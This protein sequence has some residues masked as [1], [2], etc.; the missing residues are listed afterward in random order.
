MALLDDWLNGDNWATIKTKFNAA[1]AV[2]NGFAL[3]TTGQFLRKSSSTDFAVEWVDNPLPAGGDAGDILTKASGTDYDVSW[4]TPFTDTWHSIG[5]VGEPTYENSWTTL[6]DVVQ[7]TKTADGTV[8]INGKVSGGSFA[9]IDTP[10]TLFTLPADYRP[11]TKKYASAVKCLIP[12]AA[13]RPMGYIQILT[14][15]EV[16]ISS[17]VTGSPSEF[18]VNA[19]FKI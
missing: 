14:T 11:D 18:Q 13:T 7:F 3:G 6:T 5:D 1:I 12:A 15:G 9:A 4:E 17:S 10:E 8:H 19:T 16:Q 2:I